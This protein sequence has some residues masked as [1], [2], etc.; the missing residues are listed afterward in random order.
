MKKILLR[1]FGLIL[2]LCLAFFW[3]MIN[4]K[5][6]F[7]QTKTINYGN[8]NL[9]NRDFSNLDLERAVFA[10][11]EMR[12]ANFQGSNLTNAIMSQ[13]VLLKANLEGA[14]LTGAL[15]DQVTFDNANLKNAIFKD[16]VMTRARFYDA[17]ITGADFTDA[18]IDRYQIS[19]MCKKADGINPVTG[20]ATRD[21][22]GCK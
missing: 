12:G 19:L 22:L 11:A 18:I 1:L 5:P 21:S 13:G 9:E 3:V 15:L 6:A 10:A 4:A 7:A 2:I 20:V 8:T 17:T 16:A 14:D